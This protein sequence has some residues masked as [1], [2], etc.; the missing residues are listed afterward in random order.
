MPA[1]SRRLEGRRALITGAATGIGAAIAERFAAEGAK[2]LVTARSE[3]AGRAVCARI[4]DGSGQA[5]FFPLDVCEEA[6][7]QAAVAACVEMLGGIDALVTSAGV[8]AHPEQ[9]PSPRA[10][11]DATLEQFGH[12]LDVN[13]TGTF[14]AAREAARSMV[15]TG[16]AG[17]MVF[18]SSVAAKRPTGG[19]YAVSKAGVWMLARCLAEELGPHG[20]RV[21][22]V[23]PGF[24]RT[25][26][27]EERALRSVDPEGDHDLAEA[28]LAARAAALPLRRLGTTD[29]VASAAVFLTSAES[30]YL[31]GSILHPDG[32]LVS[33]TAGG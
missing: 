15:A 16:T 13:L 8:G 1:A 30:A 11:C 22:A 31:T 26:L 19:A 18:V 10:V 3:E 29:D 28:W 4:N 20:I 9:A 33:S 12:V 7:G 2:V 27:L 32:G 25:R 24:V 5:A 14:I 6:Q 23:G 17:T 21:N